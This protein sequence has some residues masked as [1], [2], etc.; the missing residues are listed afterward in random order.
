MIVESSPIK[1]RELAGSN[2][3][4][5]FTGT[6]VRRRLASRLINANRL[7]L[8]FEGVQDISESFADECFSKL[9]RIL[10]FKLLE[11]RAVLTN[12][13]PYIESVIKKTVKNDALSYKTSLSSPA[14]RM[15]VR[16]KNNEYF[17][18]GINSRICSTYL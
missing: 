12:A 8:D 10:D 14:K 4:S 15:R 6:T 2:P 9:N 1:F 7:V 16:K 3:R 13:S 11:G 17:E 18:S 5:R